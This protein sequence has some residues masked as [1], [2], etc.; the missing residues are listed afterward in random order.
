K[1]KIPIFTV[2]V[3]EDRQT[4]S[5]NISEIQSDESVQPDQG[6]KS[7]V[8][9]DGLNLAGK[10]VDVEFD[11][12]YLGK[13]GKDANGKPIDLKTLT[14]DFTFNHLTNPKKGPYQVT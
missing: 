7:I 2:A 10:T 13:E 1:E 14:P 5:I 12:F 11:V 6:F 9:I 4:T 3:G 8:Y